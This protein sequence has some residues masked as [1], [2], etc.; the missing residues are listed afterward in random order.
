MKK[1]AVMLYSA[2]IQRLQAADNMENMSLHLVK[3]DDNEGKID[4]G[5]YNGISER[6][7]VKFNRC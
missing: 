1:I 2:V 6:D 5:F 4:Q 3:E 7:K